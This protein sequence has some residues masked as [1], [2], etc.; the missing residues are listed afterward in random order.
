M[1]PFHRIHLIVMDSVGIGAAPDAV[2][3]GD[4][5]ADTIGHIAKAVGGLQLP[6]LRGAGLGTIANITP[7]GTERKPIGYFAKMTPASRGKDTMTGHWE[8]M[9]LSLDVPF[10]VFPDGFP[11]ELIRAIEGYA[12]R[13]VIGNRA[14]S[15]TQIIQELGPEQMRSGALIVYTSADSVLQIAAHEEVV[16]LKELY[17]ICEFCRQQ[18]LKDPYM[19][20]RIIARPFTGV[21]GQFRRTSNRHDY[22]LKPCGKTA[23]NALK[24]AGL[25]VIGL[26]K[27]HD[28]FDGEGI[29]RS[30][31]T[32]SNDDGMRQ[33][34]ALASESFK[35]LS[36]LNLVDFDTLYGHRRDAKGYAGALEAFDAQ[37]KAFF[38]GLPESDLVLITADHGN[39][40]THRGTDH[41]RENVP[42]L[43][44]S[45]RFAGGSSLGVR[46]TFADVAATIAENFRVKAPQTGVSF[47]KKLV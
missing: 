2:E 11:P 4:E 15:G 47:L 12:Q 8:L 34:S 19:L 36:F 30:I 29:T 46:E 1:K 16:P 42:L 38:S 41:T 40:P 43:A 21:G 22:A 27:I 45:H 26:G 5:G 20:G 6:F 25:D 13:P 23:L 14:A 18:T 3:F 44:L 37:L 35:G 32:V 7:L 9:G 39:D 10:R 33:L 31:Y 24:D 17:A 28:I